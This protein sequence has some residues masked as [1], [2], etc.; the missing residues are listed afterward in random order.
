VI[1]T[2]A[3]RARLS[4][5]LGLAKFG[6]LEVLMIPA[7]SYRH[8]QMLLNE[9]Y[10]EIGGYPVSGIPPNRSLVGFLVFDQ[11]IAREPVSDFLENIDML[12][13]HSGDLV[14]F[15]LCGVSRYGYNNGQ[16]HKEI[17][18]LG[19]ATLYHNSPAAMSF[20]RGF[21]ESIPGWKYEMGVDLILID[22]MQVD[23]ERRLDFQSAIYFK[24]EELIKLG[25]VDRTSEF[26][27][28]IIR[29]VRSSPDRGTRAFSAS[30]KKEFGVN[31][32]KAMILALFPGAVGKLARGQAV[33][34][35]GAALPD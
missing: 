9:D 31:W 10:P 17:G 19:G 16:S 28:K 8:L 27:G 32:F 14:H 6:C 25:I 24:V 18:T 4:N 29:F 35:G 21:E 26:L 3:G 33:L 1:E 22:V 12:N 2:A 7:P 20:I 34:G 23:R 11:N 5:I 30:L 15:F 13:E